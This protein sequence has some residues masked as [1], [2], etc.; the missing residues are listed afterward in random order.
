MCA[1]SER[2]MW[3]YLGY[4]WDRKTTKMGDIKNMP[5]RDI[6]V[7]LSDRAYDALKDLED[8][9]GF[10]GSR[11]IEEVILAVDDVMQYFA[12]FQFNVA[13]IMEKRQLTPE[14]S[15]ASFSTFVS[16]LR[17]ILQRVGYDVV[18]EEYVKSRKRDLLKQKKSLDAN[19]NQK[20]KNQER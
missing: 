1:L 11:L 3:R 18:V 19:V 8:M 4:I 20:V 5:P 14:E 9:S 12:E 13:E 2:F 7:R 16:A 6:H 15:I 17:T 10:K